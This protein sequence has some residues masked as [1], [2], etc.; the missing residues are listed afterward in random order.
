VNIKVLHMSDAINHAKV[1]MPFR[2]E[3]RL[4]IVRDG[5]TFGAATAARDHR[6]G[7]TK[8]SDV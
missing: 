4:C 2:N 5:E 8:R 1:A 6:S 3:F 7:R